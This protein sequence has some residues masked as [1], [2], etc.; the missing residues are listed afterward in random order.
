M[1]TL[2]RANTITHLL[3]HLLTLLHVYPFTCLVTYTITHL[4]IQA[5]TITYLYDYKLT[6][7]YAYDPLIQFQL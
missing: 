7:L 5:D 2:S 4:L 6:Q 3:D 1:L